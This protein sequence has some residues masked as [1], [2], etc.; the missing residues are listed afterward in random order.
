MKYFGL[1][2][3]KFKPQ[4]Q[5]NFSG[6]ILGRQSGSIL[7]STLHFCALCC[8]FSPLY[9]AGFIMQD[10]ES[11]GPSNQDVLDLDRGLNVIKKEKTGTELQERG[12]PADYWKP[13]SCVQSS[14]PVPMWTGWSMRAP[15]L[16]GAVERRA[17]V[18]GRR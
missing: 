16:D 13:V 12:P 4:L 15:P 14:S 18:R 7:V 6:L 3:F 9:C 1:K 17:G 8:L 5:L 11:A 10:S 2:S